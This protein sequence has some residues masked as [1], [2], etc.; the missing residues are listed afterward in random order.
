MKPIFFFFLFICFAIIQ[1]QTNEAIQIQT[2][3][4]VKVQIN[5]NAIM[6]CTMYGND[7]TLKFI[8]WRKMME[9]AN[10]SPQMMATWN[11][12]L[13]TGSVMDPYNTRVTVSHRSILIH[14]VKEGDHACYLCSFEFNSHPVTSGKTCLSV[15]RGPKKKQKPKTTQ[16][17]KA[18]PTPAPPGTET[19]DRFNATPVAARPEPTSKITSPLRSVSC[20][21]LF[22]FCLFLFCTWH[23]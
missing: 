19:T 14:R 17:F 9:D 23:I 22:L 18:P 11:P 2:R 12:R 21:C 15:D 16:S 1:T 5:Q 13:K 6:E 7:T 4:T 3:D 10:S 20:V 8:V